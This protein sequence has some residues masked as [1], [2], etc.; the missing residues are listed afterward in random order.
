[1]R[2]ATVL[3]FS[4][5]AAA[6]FS[7]EGEADEALKTVQSRVPPIDASPPADFETASFALG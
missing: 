4:F 5:I 6:A 3:A 7:Q 1:M 2:I